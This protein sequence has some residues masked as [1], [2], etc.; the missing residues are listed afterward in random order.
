MVSVKTFGTVMVGVMAA[1]LL[2]APAY[3]DKGSADRCAAK[4]QPEA[5]AIYVASAPLLV[6]GADGAPARV[7]AIE[8]LS[9]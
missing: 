9:A 5:R 1:G 2:A 6:P 7:F 3:A 4:L 8:G